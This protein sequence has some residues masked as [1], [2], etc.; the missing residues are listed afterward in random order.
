MKA[1][2]GVRDLSRKLI[3]EFI[4]SLIIERNI[5]VRQLC[6]DAGLPFK[7]YYRIINGEGYTIDSLLA[8]LQVLDMRIEIM[9]K[10]IRK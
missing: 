2:Q 5:N 8:I 4:H 3:G 10:D 9:E 6:R 1:H 7:V